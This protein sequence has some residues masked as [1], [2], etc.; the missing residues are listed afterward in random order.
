MASNKRLIAAGATTAP[1]DPLQN[2]ETVTYTGN[3]GTQKITGY[4]RKGAAFNGSSS[5]INTSLDLDTNNTDGGSISLWFNTSQTTPFQVLIGSQTGQNGASYG[6][7]IFIGDATGTSSSESISVWDYNSSTTSAF[8]TEGGSATYQD[9]QWHHLVITS[10]SSAKNIYIDGVS[11]TIYYTAS[12][13][14]R[15]G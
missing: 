10:T 6:T 15:I 8:Y 7:S 13:S 11:Q 1:F 3:G 14:D 2:F 12:G 4:I 9:G 5:Y